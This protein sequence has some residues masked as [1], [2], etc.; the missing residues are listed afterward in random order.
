MLGELLSRGPF[1]EIPLSEAH[2]QMRGVKVVV[3]EHRNDVERSTKLRPGCKTQCGL[4][5]YRLHLVL[6]PFE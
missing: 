1:V 3:A 2:S 4:L 5:V 6:L